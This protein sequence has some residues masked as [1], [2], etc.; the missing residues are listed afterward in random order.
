MTKSYLTNI[1]AD[2][3]SGEVFAFEG[4]DNVITLV[5]GPTGCKFYHSATSQYQTIRQA[6]FDP[7]EFPEQWYFGQPRVPCTYLD[8]KDYVYGSE[9]KIIEAVTYFNEHLDY[10]L[11][12]IVNSVGA[13][14]IGDN[15]KDI[16][17]LHTNKPFVVVESPGYSLDIANGYANAMIELIKQVGLNKLPAKKLDTVNIIGLSIYH[18][19][20][21]GDIEEIKRL[22]ALC[23]I[24]VNCFLGCDCSLE[25]IQNMSSAA[26]NIVINPEFGLEIAKVLHAEYGIKY[27]VCDSLIG[28]TQTTRMLHDVASL[29][30]KEHT[31][32][33]LEEEKA[34][35]QA[36]IY[37]NRVNSLTGLPQAI[38]YALE[39]YYS[40][41]YAYANFISKYFGMYL[42]SINILNEENPT[43]QAKLEGLLQQINS[44]EALENNIEN[45]NADLVFASGNTIARLKLAQK[46]F[47]GIEINLPTLGYLDVIAKTHLGYNGALLIVEQV[48]NGLIF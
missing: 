24:K 23:D 12:C 11:L 4:I 44:V 10:D 15:I 17:A 19:Y 38:P 47:S 14:L 3:F 26:L 18:K 2:S 35:A 31:K 25:S 22:L 29:L 21:L 9:Q 34:R 7:L 43:Y 32:A 46:E 48:L 33:I 5:N 39:G 20:Y 28:F 27:Y 45:S 30:K 8:T 16:V 41:V 6:E 40:Q 36:Y 13:A 1:T 37:L 42:E